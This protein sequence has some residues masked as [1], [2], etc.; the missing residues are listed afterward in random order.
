MWTPVGCGANRYG[1][2]LQVCSRIVKALPRAA[3]LFDSGRTINLHSMLEKPQ[4]S[5]IDS[6]DQKQ[7]H[8]RLSVQLYSNGVQVMFAGGSQRCCAGYG[9]DMDAAD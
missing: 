2:N 7:A 6:W 8:V 9:S 3:E 4:V 5:F 1:W